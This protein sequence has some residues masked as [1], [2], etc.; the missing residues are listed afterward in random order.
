MQ[1][2]PS[3]QVA[4][5]A[6]VNPANN[7]NSAANS[8]AVDM[9][10]FREAMFAL[11]L[12]AAA[13]QLFFLLLHKGHWPSLRHLLTERAVQRFASAEGRPWRNWARTEAEREFRETL[14]KGIPLFPGTG[15]AHQ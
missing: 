13:I 5:V 1:A 4:V 2:Q 15:F 12:G 10:K 7:N 6:K 9:S 8:D 14:R 3:E 11:I